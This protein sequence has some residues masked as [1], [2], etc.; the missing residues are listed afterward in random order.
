MAPGTSWS[1]GGTSGRTGSRAS[2]TWPSTRRACSSCSHR[3]WSPHPSWSAWIRRVSAVT[4]PPCSWRGFRAGSGGHR[5]TSTG[6]WTGSSTPCWRSTACRCP[7]PCRSVASSRTPKATFSP[8]RPDRRVPRRG[9]ARSRCTRGR[10]PP[11]NAPSSTATS[12][13]ATSSGRATRSPA[14][15]TGPTPASGS[16]EADVGHC[17]INVARHL[18][19]EVA[20][21]LT[22]RYLERTGRGVST[23]RTGISSTRWEC[24]TT[25][26]RSSDGCP[27]STSSSVPSPASTVAVRAGRPWA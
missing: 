24:W 23:T 3:R 8:H 15:S 25:P 13:R 10:R 16:P 18:G 7:P 21:Q 22:A 9:R 11:P 20:E 1:C 6:S 19:Y 17:R 27:R 4:C 5:R 14:W 26:G 12:T 2:R